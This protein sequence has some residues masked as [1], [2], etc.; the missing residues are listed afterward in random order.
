MTKPEPVT[1]LISSTG[2]KD[3]VA[4]G[5]HDAHGA[6]TVTATRNH[7]FWSVQHGRWVNAGQLVPG[8]QLRRPDGGV[9]TVDTVKLRA[10]VS[11]VHNLSV[12]E[13]HTYY[14][15][16]G[17]TPVLVHNSTCILLGSAL[18]VA[19][20]ANPLMESLR[21][22]GKLPPNFVT[23]ETA[24][25]AGWSKGKALGNHI[26]QG[27]IGGDVYKNAPRDPG[28]M[29]LPRAPGRIYYEADVGLDPA[30]TR[31][32]QAG[33]RLVYSNDG[34]AYVSFNHYKLF[35]QLPNWK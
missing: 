21:T 26:P 1:D 35:Y 12:E 30:M 24:E 5:T 6:G 11:R 20:A 22:V 8:E 17:E 28:D 23:K 14:V 31:G 3:L 27:Q 13:L 33:W 18:S 29:L 9:A 32:K 15:L 2:K 7:P 4:V 19:E 16:A 25:A 10:E 34:L